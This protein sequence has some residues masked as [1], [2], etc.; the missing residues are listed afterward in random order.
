VKGSPSSKTASRMV[1]T[2]P[3]EPVCAVNEAPSR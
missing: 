3:M 2:G 1:D